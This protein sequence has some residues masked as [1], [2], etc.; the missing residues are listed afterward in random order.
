VYFCDFGRYQRPFAPHQSRRIA[1]I[2]VCYKGAS[3]RAVK[4]VWSDRYLET[5]VHDALDAQRE[6][7]WLSPD[8]IVDQ[9]RGDLRLGALCRERLGWG[10]L[11]AMVRLADVG[12]LERLLRAAAFPLVVPLL[13]T[14]ILRDRAVRGRSWIACLLSL[15]S[16]VLLLT[17]WSAG[18]AVGYLLG[19][20][21]EAAGRPRS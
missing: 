11:H 17:A 6:T 21:I 16:T 5:L 9:V 8:L 1:D 18:E 2:N 14:R 13:L 4:G 10:R 15:P 3:I 20:P 19:R 12:L 7:M